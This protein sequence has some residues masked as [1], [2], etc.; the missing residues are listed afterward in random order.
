MRYKI[1]DTITKE[2]LAEDKFYVIPAGEIKDLTGNIIENKDR[3]KIIVE[4]P[5]MGV[6]VEDKYICKRTDKGYWTLEE[7][8][9]CS[10][11]FGDFNEIS[12]AIAALGGISNY[13]IFR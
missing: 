13:E 10:Y 8:F 3:F 5:D 1:Y 7:G 12:E 6:K 4:G 11:C 2:Y 9:C